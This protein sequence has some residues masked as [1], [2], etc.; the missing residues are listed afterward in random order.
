MDA[1]LD[2]LMDASASHLFSPLFVPMPGEQYPAPDTPDT[3]PNPSLLRAW[4]TSCVPLPV[5]IR[6][7]DPSNTDPDSF[8]SRYPYI[9]YSLDVETDNAL[10]PDAMHRVRKTAALLNTRH[11]KDEEKM[12][13]YARLFNQSK[14]YPTSTP[15]PQTSTPTQKTSTP[16]QK[17]KAPKTRIPLLT[18]FDPSDTSPASV[19]K[20]TEYITR[21]RRQQA[22]ADLTSSQTLRNLLDRIVASFLAS[23]DPSVH[24]RIS[25]L[26]QIAAAYR[27]I[28]AVQRV[29]LGLPADNVGFD[30]EGTDSR[31][32]KLPTINVS[33][34]TLPPKE[35]A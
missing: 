6:L 12:V 5:F 9:A 20:L 30:L 31:G 23:S 22:Q 15:T 29:G 13:T 1:T 24:V 18:D 34:A 27:D 17:T 32:R 14:A 3:G 28:Q 4:V 11:D 16:T 25:D 19:K 7:V 8:R 35:S 21:F 26:R 33:L 10:S 2:D